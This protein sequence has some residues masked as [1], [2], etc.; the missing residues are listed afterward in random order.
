[1]K[2]KHYK[3]II[4]T[5][6]LAWVVSLPYMRRI[7]TQYVT[8]VET[9]LDPI[10]ESQNA[11]RAQLLSVYEM[12]PERANWWAHYIA[13]ASAAHHVPSNI[14]ISVISVES[15]FQL[16]VKS[17]KGA[18]GPAQVIPSTWKNSLGFNIQDPIQNIYAG[19]YILSD[20]KKTCGNWDC[21]LKAYNVGITNYLKGKK[22]TAQTRYIT[23][24]KVELAMLDTFTVRTRGEL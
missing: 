11:V 19:A 6:I 14:L 23:K 22:K 2:T 15:E 1:M 20:Y 17:H 8:I 4:A 24:V 9:K 12:E 7:E 13:Y 10:T 3:L 18:V 5:M 16:D 21:A